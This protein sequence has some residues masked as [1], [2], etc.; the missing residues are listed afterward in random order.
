[1]MCL[2]IH[3]ISS[4][5]Q[6]PPRSEPCPALPRLTYKCQPG[7]LRFV[8]ARTNPPEQ[9]P[10]L[11][12]LG[13]HMYYKGIINCFINS[14]CP[15]FLLILLFT[16]CGQYK[17][18]NKYNGQINRYPMAIQ[19]GLLITLRWICPLSTPHSLPFKSSS[20]VSPWTLSTVK[21][22]QISIPMW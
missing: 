11:L 19:P 13:W 7:A 20:R 2:S 4:I 17:S 1:M 16:T 8:E 12:P 21:T 14:Q 15:S 10:W 3:L 9:D 22:N 18:T 5:F 6:S